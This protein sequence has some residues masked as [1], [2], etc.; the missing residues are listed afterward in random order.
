MCALQPLGHF[1]S[2]ERLDNS[3]CCVTGCAILN[4]FLVCGCADF[5]VVIPAAAAAL[6]LS[7]CHITYRY[8]CLTKQPAIYVLN[9]Q[10]NYI[11]LF[12]SVQLHC[13]CNRAP[14]RVPFCLLS[15][16]HTHTHT[17]VCVCVCV[18]VCARTAVLPTGTVPGLR[19]GGTQFVSCCPEFVH[20]SFA[21]SSM[22]NIKTRTALF[23]AITQRAV[24]IYHRRFGTTYWSRQLS[25]NVGKVLQ[26]AA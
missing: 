1:D 13:A 5:L 11:S 24:V 21:L 4:L 3:V 7:V 17:C 6:C 25:H 10:L 8:R 14:S 15:A 12:D 20:I 22:Y 16:T 19:L 9:F 2:K 26:H 18:C 23:W